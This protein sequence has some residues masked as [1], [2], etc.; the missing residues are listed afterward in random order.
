MIKGM[1]GYYNYVCCIAVKLLQIHLIAKYK[2]VYEHELVYIKWYQKHLHED[3][4]GIS[5]VVCSNTNDSDSPC[6]FIPVQRIHAVCEHCSY[7]EYT[8]RNH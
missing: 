7:T 2:Q 1:R 5:A 3:W 4:H 8:N 6:S